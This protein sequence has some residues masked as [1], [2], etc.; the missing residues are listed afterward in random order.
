MLLFPVGVEHTLDEALMT[1]TW[2]NIVGP[3]WCEKASLDHGD[4][5]GTLGFG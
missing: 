2:A 4:G 5:C 1:P 3:F